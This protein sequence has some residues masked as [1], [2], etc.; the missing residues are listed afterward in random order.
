MIM[1]RLSLILAIIVCATMVS[2]CSDTPFSTNAPDRIQPVVFPEDTLD[3]NHHGI[4]PPIDLKLES[5]GSEVD[6]CWC[7]YRPVSWGTANSDCP[8]AFRIYRSLNDGDF[9]FVGVVYCTGY[10]ENL[11]GV[12][13]ERM[14]WY[15]TSISL[16]G[17]ESA[18]SDVV[19]IKRDALDNTQFEDTPMER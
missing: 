4:A 15:V 17:Q 1:K 8:Y 13:F 19:S 3:P 10:C 14:S 12:E 7:V 2:N 11:E 6:I 5:R 9:D 16:Q 18:P